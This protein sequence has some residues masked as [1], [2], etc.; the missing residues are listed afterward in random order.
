MPMP[1][2]MS[3]AEMSE[4]QSASTGKV[5]A[6]FLTMM[7]QHHR[8]A[9]TMAK[10]DLKAGTNSDAEKLATAIIKAQTAE[11]AEMKAMLKST[12]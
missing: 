9:I 7:Q 8:G 6:V 5:D 2:M 3:D 11:I 4:L 1:G 12:S 10:E